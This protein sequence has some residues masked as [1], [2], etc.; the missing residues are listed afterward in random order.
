MRR[1]LQLARLGEGFTSPNPMVGAVIVARGKVIG[2]GYHRRCG[3]PHAEVWAVRSVS[4]S[5][6][7]LL[8]EA[9]VYVTLEPCS[10][11]GKTP[12]CANMLVEHGVKRVVVGC[13]DPNPKVAGRGVRILREAG[14]E[15]TV[16]VLRDECSNLNRRFMTAQIKRRPYILLKWAMSKD[17]FLD[18][19]RT[20][21]TD[22]VKFS[23]QMSFQSMHRLR[24]LHDAIMVGAGTVLSDNPS[25]TVRGYAGLQPRPVVLDRRGRVPASAKVFSNSQ[26][27]YVTAEARQDL[28]AHVTQVLVSPCAS[29]EAVV[30]ELKALGISSIMVEGGAELLRSFMDCGLWDDARVEVAPFALG[31][32]GVSAVTLPRGAV[33]VSPAD[34][35]NV[36]INVKNVD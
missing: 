3:G 21:G 29:V 28:P 23:T 34:A 26:A 20:P 35:G 6:R 8:S 5:D 14:I 7:H 15:V 2:E 18:R 16:D 17:G 33:S 27:I 32:S 22:A 1:A 13:P 30:G 9:T 10:H 12:P 19:E 25:L 31:S 4:A 24:S 11:Y 36:I